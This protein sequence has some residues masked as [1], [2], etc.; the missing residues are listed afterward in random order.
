VVL[1]QNQTLRPA[2]QIGFNQ[3]QLNSNAFYFDSQYNGYIFDPN[4]PTNEYFQTASMTKPMLGLGLIHQFS[5]NKQYFLQSG[6]GLFNLTRPNQSFF[7]DN[8]QRD[9]RLNFFS[10]LRYQYS[11]SLV[12]EP[13]FQI[14][15]QG[16]YKT[17]TIGSTGEYLF[18]RRD[19]ITLIAG[20]WWRT[21]DALCLQF[22]MAKGP[23]STG[24]SYDFNY[25]SLVP[26]SR[27]RGAFELSLRYVFTKFNP[28]QLQYRICPDFI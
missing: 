17:M 2:L 4:A 24:I 1:N 8:T 7:N 12:L 26:A 14:N 25:S 13:S 22:G 15:F 6:L 19:Q 20:F 28:P 5:I 10:Q 21:N 9:I 18:S 11:K 3:R 23:L 16:P 27:A